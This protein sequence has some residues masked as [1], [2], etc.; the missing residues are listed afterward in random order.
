MFTLCIVLAVSKY[1]MP[2]TFK[3]HKLHLKHFSRKPKRKYRG[4]HICTY[5][6]Q[7][8]NPEND[9]ET[10]G[11]KQ[12]VPHA[13]QEVDPLNNGHVRVAQNVSR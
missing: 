7:F 1:R 2:A 4:S 8:F 11:I 5:M 6:Q 9:C 13:T 12:Q 3:Q 10:S